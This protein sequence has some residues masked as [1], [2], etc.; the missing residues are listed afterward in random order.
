VSPRDLDFIMRRLRLSSKDL[1]AALDIKSPSLI[2]QWR[3]GLRS[4]PP[5]KAQAIREYAAKRGVTAGPE[6]VDLQQIDED[7]DA[8]YTHW[9]DPDLKVRPFGAAR[10]RRP[11]AGP[12]WG[13]IGAVADAANGLVAALLGEPIGPPPDDPMRLLVTRL[14]DARQRGYNLGAAIGLAAAGG[15][16]EPE[17]LPTAL[18]W[19]HGAPPIL[20]MRGNMIA[21][22]PGQ[23]A[24]PS[25]VDI[26]GRPVQPDPRPRRGFWR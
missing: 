23:T 12:E 17:A 26:S 22:G 14:I 25:L 1:A 9:G 8:G 11:R 4:I 21:I 19:P 2:R 13:A 18:L 15:R 10:R 5:H 3:H 6:T 16:R 7:R 24:G 20:P